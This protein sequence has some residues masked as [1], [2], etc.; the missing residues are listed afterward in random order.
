MN[1]IDDLYSKLTNFAVSQ[2]TKPCLKNQDGHSLSYFE[3]WQSI[4]A[5][6]FYL[7]NLGI[8]DGDSILVLLPNSIDQA[9]LFLASICTGL[10]FSP[11]ACMSTIFE[12]ESTIANV[13]PVHIFIGDNL[14]MEKINEIQ[15][16]GLAT[17]LIPLNTNLVWLPEKS[18]PIS[19]KAGKLLIS[20]SGSTGKSKVV[21]INSSSLWQSAADFTTFHNNRLIDAIYWN[22]LPMSYLGGLFNLLLIPL[23]TGATILIDEP[24]SGSTFIKFWHM[25]DKFRINAIW[26]VPSILRG[27]NQLAFSVKKETS[28]RIKICFIGTAPVTRDEKE[29]FYA[30][31]GIQ[32]IENYGLTET[33]FISS[34]VSRSL[35]IAG[36]SVEGFV[37][38]ILP[39]VQVVCKHSEN[40]IAD[41]KFME[42]WIKSPYLMEGYLESA[43]SNADLT[44]DS[45]GY[46]DTGDLGYVQDN[47]LILTG[48][49]KDI[50]KKG[51]QLINLLELEH[52]AN[53]I[54]RVNHSIAIPIKHKFYG[55]SFVLVVQLNEGEF[56][57]ESEIS[58]ELHKQVSKFKWPEKIVFVDKIP[59]T[60]SGKINRPALR[61][62]IL[63]MVQN[64]E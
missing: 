43:N 44:L 47:N 53:R 31:F 25:V 42:I 59:R 57:T 49:K 64:A 2:P 32:A 5:A 21:V 37:G 8:G 58:A 63:K 36:D 27:L 18:E 29:L 20:T 16:L 24:F 34:E 54:D 10:Q 7:K 19:F 41:P 14:P 3:I 6:N 22:Y 11:L 50:I 33:T 30:N 61:D 56:L 55:E 39:W 48:R 45:D 12:I 60:E 9:V 13:N 52:L 1:T 23:A 15:S 17:T 26:L 4:Q 28:E 51:G 35:P 40:G 46:F 38:Q 62:T